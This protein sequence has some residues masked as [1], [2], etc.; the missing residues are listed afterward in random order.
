[1]D[2]DEFHESAFLYNRRDAFHESTFFLACAGQAR[3]Q[4]QSRK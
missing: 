1:M 2:L 4:G 3:E